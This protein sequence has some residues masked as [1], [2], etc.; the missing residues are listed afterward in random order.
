MTTFWKAILF[1]AAW[2][3]LWIGV[4]LYLARR[5]VRTG[6]VYDDSSHFGEPWAYRATEPERFWG[7]V[8]F[9]YGLALVGLLPWVM[10]LVF[11][12]KR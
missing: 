5:A 7:V 11:G 8:H 9:Y 1:C 6:R 12:I 2:S 3:A 10:I 4:P